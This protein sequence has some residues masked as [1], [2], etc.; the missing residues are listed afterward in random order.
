MTCPTPD[1]WFSDRVDQSA[2]T[3]LAAW[4][5]THTSWATQQKTA[6]REDGTTHVKSS[7][8]PRDG[9][10]GRLVTFCEI[11]APQAQCFRARLKRLGVAPKPS[12]AAATADDKQETRTVCPTCGTTLIVGWHQL[13]FTCTVAVALYHAT[14][15]LTRGSQAVS[16]RASY[17]HTTCFLLKSY[18]T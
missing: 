18:H 9:P 4:R 5:K 17:R 7:I 14:A 8:S 1:H 15:P 11:I 16:L 2:S 6:L 13:Y 10:N 3:P 12:I